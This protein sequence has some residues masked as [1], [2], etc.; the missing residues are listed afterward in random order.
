MRKQYVYSFIFP[1]LIKK[2]GRWTTG[3]LEGTITFCSLSTSL[4]FIWLRD[5]CPPHVYRV[6]WLVIMLNSPNPVNSF[7]SSW[8][9]TVFRFGLVASGQTQVQ[10]FL[11]SRHPTVQSH[12][13]FEAFACDSRLVTLLHPISLYCMCHCSLTPHLLYCFVIVLASGHSPLSPAP[14]TSTTFRS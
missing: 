7:D 13:E 4:H 1:F 2:F 5:I 8:F 10:F 11:V 14:I 9:V 6:D 12:W 3:S